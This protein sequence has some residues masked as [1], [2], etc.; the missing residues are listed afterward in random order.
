MERKN[1]RSVFL[2]KKHTSF[3]ETC[4]SGCVSGCL[5]WIPLCYLASGGSKISKQTRSLDSVLLYCLRR[6]KDL[7]KN[8]S[9]EEKHACIA[10]I[11]QIRPYSPI[12]APY[13]PLFAPG[14]H[15]VIFGVV[16]LA[17]SNTGQGIFNVLPSCIRRSEVI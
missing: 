17:E 13:R 15:I 5:P 6:V 9:L 7:K 16:D 12:S 2:E 4:V 14:P 1:A 3:L 11:A 8:T 10:Y